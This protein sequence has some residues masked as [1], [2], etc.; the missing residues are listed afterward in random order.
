MSGSSLFWQLF[1]HA[2]EDYDLLEP[3]RAIL[4]IPDDSLRQLYKMVGITHID[5]LNWVFLFNF[6]ANHIVSED[7]GKSIKTVNGETYPHDPVNRR[8]GN[9]PYRIEYSEN[10]PT[11]WSFPGIIVPKDSF[12]DIR[13]IANRQAEFRHG[14][15]NIDWTMIRESLFKDTFMDA[16]V[17]GSSPPVFLD[18]MKPNDIQFGAVFNKLREFSRAM[19]VKDAPSL[20]RQ[21]TEILTVSS[22]GVGVMLREWEKA[23][24]PKESGARAQFWYANSRDVRT[25]YVFIYADDTNYL[26]VGVVD[27]YPFVAT[28]FF[29]YY[30]SHGST[31]FLFDVH[32]N[33]DQLVSVIESEATSYAQDTLD[34]SE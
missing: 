23:V 6:I 20:V 13:D 12:I 24:T 8:I 2:R 7:N 29:S 21:D 15:Y 11:V 3:T 32:T 31:S 19:G 16:V 22:R 14:F 1:R 33:L 28:K 4:V 18:E 17:D 9:I 5:M 34:G 30:N 10:P 27:A 26:A 25:S